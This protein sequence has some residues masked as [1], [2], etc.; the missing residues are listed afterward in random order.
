MQLKKF[1]Q[2]DRYGNMNSFEF[3]IPPMNEVPQ[4]DHPGGP[5]GTDTVPA[6]LTPG[7]NVVN[8]EASRLYQPMIDKMN[9]KGRAIQAQQGGPVPSYEASGG[10]I[11]ETEANY[12]G[13]NTYSD[14]FGKPYQ[15]NKLYQPINDSLIS[16]EVTKMKEM[17]LPNNQMMSAL[18]DNL[19]LNS[20]QALTAM[21]P[22]LGASSIGSTP[23]TAS[24]TQTPLYNAAGTPPKNDIVQNFMDQSSRNHDSAYLAKKPN[25]LAGGSIS[26]EL[27]DA[28]EENMRKYMEQA[29]YNQNFIS[30]R[31]LAE[32]GVIIDDNILDGMMQVESN[33]NPNAVSE[34]GAIGPMQIMPSTALNPGYG[35]A[36]ISLEDLRDPTLSKEFARRYMQ[37]LADRNPQLNVDE[38]KTAY[39]SGLGNVL[40]ARSGEEAL[41]PRGQAYAGKVNAAMGEVP[42]VEYDGRAIPSTFMSANAATNNSVPKE[43]GYF[44]QIKN[45][46]DP[47][48]SEREKKDADLLKGIET[49]ADPDNR[50]GDGTKNKDLMSLLGVPYYA[51]DPP[52]PMTDTTVSDN[53]DNRDK[54]FYDFKNNKLKG[55]LNTEVVLKDR[56][57]RI[58]NKAKESVANGVSPSDSVLSQIKMLELQISKNNEYISQTQKDIDVENSEAIAKKEKINIALGIPPKTVDNKKIETVKKIIQ[59]TN[60]ADYDEGK[61]ELDKADDEWA[62]KNL[63]GEFEGDFAQNLINK[64]KEYGGPILDKSME[65]FKNAF[66]SMFDGEELARMAMIYAGSRAM[67][68]DHG[69]SLNYSMKSYMKRVDGNLAR[70]KAFSLTEKAR[71]DYTESSLKEY[72]KTGKR[73][74]LIP[75]AGGAAMKQ[76]S[77]SAYL[78]GVGKVQKYK[79]TNGVEYISYKGKPVPVSSLLG[80][81]EPWDES[82]QGDKAVSGEYSRFAEEA[83][84]VANS[85]YGLSSG[86]KNKETYDTT[87]KTNSIKIGKEANRVYRDIIRKNHLSVNDTINMQSSINTAIENYVDDLARWES[88]GKEKGTKPNG[89][90]GYI[91]ELVRI[92][93]TGVETS[94]FSG[95]STANLNALDDKIRGEMDIKDPRNP[96]FKKEYKADWMANQKS[97]IAISK[98][99]KAKW[100]ARAADKKNFSGFTLWASKTS[101]EEKAKFL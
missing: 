23:N 3:D 101:A 6:W 1:T 73:D 51:E 44:D 27:A 19:N 55:A 15:V 37:E 43:K 20:N 13:K 38:I 49:E 97:W 99:D 41:G 42:P 48:M 71:D 74:A 84:K 68:Y 62:K 92:P 50:I 31:H 72:S 11:G 30:N 66:S 46:F 81:I 54:E 80:Y 77:G 29:K 5:K 10:I 76:T 16:N 91:D 28:D 85:S 57:E 35:V 56:L 25:Y 82:V 52:L 86:T 9:N 36:P 94:L 61:S 24:T 7:E 8:A 69:G 45:F 4:P 100:I 64:A 60:T 83:T 21:Q 17:G 26:R 47:E 90:E 58:K 2:K 33:G 63:T 67:G 93:L 88:G 12:G 65:F 40:K 59:D 39:H 78:R 18:E 95:T 89:V 22:N 75:K 98:E 34:A 32:G 14:Y 96:E 53:T 70:A 87:I 79:D